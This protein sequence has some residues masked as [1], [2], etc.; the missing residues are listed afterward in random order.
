MFELSFGKILL[1]AVIA[2]IV[3]GP[4]RLPKVA[5]T[6]GQWIGRVQSF[7]SN[8]KNELNQEIN[9]VELN[10]IK[11][12]IESA[13]NAMRAEM[14]S[15]LNLMENELSQMQ[16][17][18]GVDVGRDAWKNLPPMRT[19]DDFAEE[20]EWIQAQQRIGEHD[21]SLVQK[22]RQVKRQRRSKPFVNP[23]LRVR[24]RYHN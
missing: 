5:R 6:L 7:V 1:F 12:D 10:K 2:L 11:E 15:S 24:R 19:V 21:L 18:V 23:K 8:V 9:N 20:R 3:L 16:Q 4:E 13:A 22:S 14:Q 17:Q